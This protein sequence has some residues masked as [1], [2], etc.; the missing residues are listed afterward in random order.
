VFKIAAIGFRPGE[1]I[2]YY[3]TQPDQRVY[4]SVEQA[5][6]DENG[7]VIGA[8]LQHNSYALAGIWA[9]SLEGV[10]SHHKSVA[11]LKLYR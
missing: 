11:F 8:T 9:V 5:I 1:H 7:Y 4:G 2:G 10:E 3:W 6:A